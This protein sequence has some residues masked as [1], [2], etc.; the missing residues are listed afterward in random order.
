MNSFQPRVAA[1]EAGLIYTTEP[2]FTAGFAMFLPVLLGRLAGHPY[3]N[4]SLTT[5]LVAGGSLILAANLLM[6]WK[7]NP[8]PPSIA[9]AP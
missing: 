9:P 7:Q 1:T 4:E 2:L 6:Q 3:A 5:S 8:H